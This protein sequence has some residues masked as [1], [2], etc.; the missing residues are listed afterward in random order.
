MKFIKEWVLPLAIGLAIALIVRTFLFTVVRVDGTSMEPNLQNNELVFESKISSYT[1]GDVVVFDATHED[2]ANDGTAKD[3][4]K[5]IIGVGGDT[6][7]FQ[8]GKLYV[9]NKE[10]NQNFL[11]TANKTTGTAGTFGNTWSLGTLSKN[12]SWQTKDRNKVKVPK[13]MYFVLGDNRAVSNDSRTF[14]FVEKQHILGKVYAPIWNTDATARKN[15]N[16]QADD[17]FVK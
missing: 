10:V 2:P 15:I 11:P 5:R 14:G 16:K 8:D 4:V 13:G 12:A 17:F 9:N 6:V 3:Y 1:R 7:S